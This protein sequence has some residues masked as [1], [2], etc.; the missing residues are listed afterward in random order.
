MGS[1]LRHLELPV[2]NFRKLHF[3]FEAANKFFERRLF[4]C[5]GALSSQL[6]LRS[7]FVDHLDEWVGRKSSGVVFA[8]GH[9]LVKARFFSAIV[10]GGTLKVG[11]MV[12]HIG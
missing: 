5:G 11:R 4:D 12:V 7:K 3:V 2:G 6:P 10:L 9:G 1:F 8:C